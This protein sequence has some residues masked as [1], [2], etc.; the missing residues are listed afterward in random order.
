MSNQNR[1][2]RCTP[3]DGRRRADLYMNNGLRNSSYNYKN[4]VNEVR[5]LGSKTLSF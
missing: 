1:R 3:T 5:E 2:P 4:Y